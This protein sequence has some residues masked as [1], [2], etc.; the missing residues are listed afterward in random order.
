MRRSVRFSKIMAHGLVLSLVMLAG[1][2]KFLELQR[3]Q[4]ETPGPR[5]YV[6]NESSNSVTV[7]D[8][9]TF[10]VIGT[11]DARGYSTHD[12]SLTRD[13]KRLFAT[14]LA[15]GRLSVIDTD[16][17]ETIASI[18]T[19]SRCHVVTLTNDNRQAWVANIAEDNI[20]IVD[21]QSYRILGTIPVGKGPTGLAF[22]RDGRFAYVSNQGDK[23]VQVIDTATHRIVKTVPVGAN[24]HFLVLGPDGRIWGTNTGGT[25]IYVID[26][27]THEKIATFE[28]GPTPQQIAFAYKGMVGPNAYVTVGGLNKVV[29]V[30]ADPKDL[31]IV[32]QIDVGQRPNGIWANPEGTRVYVGHEGSNDLRVI[33]TGT[34]QA[35]ATV[36]VGRKPIRVV[37]SR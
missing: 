7:V 22:S 8:A 4:T 30:K 20:S 11:V 26:P 5:V 12:L 34:S 6:A 17:L 24:P 14:N 33:D 31:R 9:T 3:E 10:K 18:P 25:D 35:I 27:A 15:S 29:A 37:V 23:A 21:T 28:V 2:A 36:P 13:G 1:C 16:A 19:G 32:D